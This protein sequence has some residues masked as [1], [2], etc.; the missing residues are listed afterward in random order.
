MGGAIRQRLQAGDGFPRSQSAQTGF[1]GQTSLAYGAAVLGLCLFCILLLALSYQK[2]P[3]IECST[4]AKKPR[5]PE[6]RTRQDR[7][8]DVCAG[9]ENA[10]FTRCTYAALAIRLDSSNTEA[11]KTVCD[12]LTKYSWPIPA[13]PLLRSVKAGPLLAAAFVDKE[14]KAYA[15]SA[16]GALLAWDGKGSSFSE[17]SRLYPEDTKISQ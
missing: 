12:L 5:I 6:T 2:E 16:D 15:V 14:N 11:V 4:Q 9:S 10:L 8:Y 3:A 7:P 13:S 1:T 17:L